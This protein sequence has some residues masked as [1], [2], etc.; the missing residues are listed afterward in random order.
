MR[1]GARG[2]RYPNLATLTAARVARLGR[3]NRA[4]SGNTGR[5]LLLTHTRV[6]IKAAVCR[7]II[8]NCQCLRL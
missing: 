8:S 3:G 5:S 1:V 2:A 6:G 4:Q 7:A